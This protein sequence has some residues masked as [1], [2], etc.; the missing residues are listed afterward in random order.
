VP[1]GLSLMSEQGSSSTLVIEITRETDRIRVGLHP[2]ADPGAGTLL[3][4]EVQCY[5][6]QELAGVSQELF[7]VMNAFNEDGRLAEHSLQELKRLGGLLLDLVFPAGTKSELVASRAER[8]LLRIDS[9]LVCVP[10]E[11]LYDGRQFFCLRWEMGRVVRTPQRP[12]PTFPRKLALPLRMLVVAD[13]RGDLP[14]AYEEG[15]RIRDLLDRTPERVEGELLSLR[16]SPDEVRR[17][18]KESDVLHYAGHADYLPGDPSGSGWLLEGGK[19]TAGHV[20]GMAGCQGMPALVFVNACRSGQTAA[21]PG[22]G[23]RNREIFG[24]ANAFLL[25]GASHYIGT[26]WEIQDEPS[27]RF[28]LGFYEGLAGGASVGRALQEARRATIREFGESAIVWAT[29]MLYGDPGFVCVKTDP[30]GRAA[31]PRESARTPAAHLPG[32]GAGAEPARFRGEP[33]AGS[34]AATPGDAGPGGAGPGPGRGGRGRVFR[35]AGLCLLALLLGGLFFFQRGGADRRQA[36][37][38]EARGDLEGAALRYARALEDEP[39]DRDVRVRLC[40]LLNRMGRF[41]ESGECLAALMPVSGEDRTELHLQQGLESL[42]ADNRE[43]WR[44]ER[45]DALLDQLAEAVREGGEGGAAADA[46][47]EWT[48][49]PLPVAVLGV[50]EFGSQPGGGGEG[51]Q[52]VL[53][54]QEGL[55]RSP[56][57]RLVDRA[58]LV[59][60]LQELKLGANQAAQPSQALRLGQLLPAHLLILGSLYRDPSACRVHLRIVET[61]TS[62]VAAAFSHAFEPTLAL[63]KAGAEAAGKI[64]EELGKAYPLRGRVVSL[65]ADGDVVLDLGRSLGITE[66][67]GFRVLSGTDA[68]VRPSPARVRVTE[69]REDTA[70]ARLLEPAAVVSPGDR[71]VES[72]EPEP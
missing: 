28:A 37:T 48:R 71:V 22:P 10:W 60:V 39:G 63:E 42:L 3:P 17:R 36:E 13:P 61:E 51:E 56:R 46:G 24:L 29:Y 33:H 68:G 53:W 65:G 69:V 50:E 12:L 64:L 25:A 62:R 31:S 5:D 6:P 34:S 47:T 1:G 4:Y 58:V 32:A 23:G 57:V 16:V 67:A 27:S 19:F 11:L 59:S 44:S 15:V 2:G 30:L 8:M 7:R 9:E 43:R 26:F 70:V 54:I 66:G 49:Q 55:R 52:L 18:L 72:F 45:A 38:L 21:W 14:S 35:T 40:G 20:L 41:R